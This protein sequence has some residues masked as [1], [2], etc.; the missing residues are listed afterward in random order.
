MPAPIYTYTPNVPQAAQKISATQ[1]PIANNF[2][3]IRELIEVNHVGFNT[4]NDFGKHKSILMPVQVAAPAFAA[5][6]TGVYNKNYATTAKNETYV[7]RQ[8]QAGTEDVPFTASILSNTAPA[9]NMQGWT[10]LPSGIKLAWF[11]TGSQNGLVT[12]NIGA[13]IPAFNHIFAIYLTPLD[14]AA[15]DVDFVVRLVNVISAAQFRVYFSKRTSTGAATG[16]ANVL[17]IGR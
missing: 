2:Q 7:H 1:S 16:A 6:E 4:V 3:A 17:V 9:N 14:P 15:G 13:P 5:G 11:G 10:Y 8:N 12:V